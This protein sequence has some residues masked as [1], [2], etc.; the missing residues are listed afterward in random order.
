MR[1]DPSAVPPIDDWNRLLDGRVAVVTGGGAGIGA[2]I[3]ELF[4]SHGAVLEIAEIDPDRAA[5]VVETIQAAGGEARAHVV[6]VR[7]ED[8]VGELARATL[9]RHGS[10]DV[11]VNNVG[12]YRPQ[13]RSPNRGPSRGRRCTGSTSG[14]SSP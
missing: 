2:G 14:T 6:D 3:C 4:A 13:V 7:T 9:D 11:L 12:D 5:A 8:G 10:I 1:T